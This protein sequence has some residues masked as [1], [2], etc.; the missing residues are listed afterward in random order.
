[1]SSATPPSEDMLN[2][3][4]E[5]RAEGLSWDRV[6][7]RI[8]RNPR[9]LRKWLK[10]PAKYGVSVSTEIASAYSQYTSAM[11]AGL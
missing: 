6:A 2:F 4:A 1:M 3:V 11:T 8:K 5:L 9:T 7:A 10:S